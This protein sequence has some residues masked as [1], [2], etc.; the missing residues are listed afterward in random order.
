MSTVIAKIDVERQC[1]GCGEKAIITVNNTDYR[2]W[3]DG[4]YVQDA[5]PYLDTD[6]RETF[7]S[8]MCKTCWNN[9]FKE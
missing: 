2:A 7:I 5:F 1:P 6:Q 9:F 4:K 3:K 8:G